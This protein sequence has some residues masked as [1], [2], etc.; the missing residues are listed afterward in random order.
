MIPQIQVI[1]L[2]LDMINGP[3]SGHASRGVELSLLEL[4]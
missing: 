3:A 2:Q 1:L 4:H